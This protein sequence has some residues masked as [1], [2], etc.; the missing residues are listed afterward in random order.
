MKDSKVKHQVMPSL[1]WANSGFTRQ[2]TYALTTEAKQNI[3]RMMKIY[4]FGDGLPTDLT[5]IFVYPQSLFTKVAHS[6]GCSEDHP[7]S[8]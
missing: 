2:Y 4:T 3:M 8:T 5:F 1:H 7:Q 6:L